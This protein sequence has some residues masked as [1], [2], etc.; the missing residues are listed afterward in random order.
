MPAI[1]FGDGAEMSAATWDGLLDV[2]RHAQ[3]DPPPSLD[4]MIGELEIRAEVLTGQPVNLPDQALGVFQMLENIRL[5]VITDRTVVE[6]PKREKSQQRVA[7]L[8]PR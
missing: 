4:A 6:N 2:L 5:L 3:F 8:R 7:M 1:R